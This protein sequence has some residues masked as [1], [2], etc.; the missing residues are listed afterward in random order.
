MRKASLGWSFCAASVFFA[1]IA[2]AVTYIALSEA[3]GSGPPYYGRTQNMDKWTDPIPVLALLDLFCIFS[4]ALL[5]RN[6]MRLLRQSD[7]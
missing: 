5:F 6:G 2:I 1:I 4:A 7:A 3:Y